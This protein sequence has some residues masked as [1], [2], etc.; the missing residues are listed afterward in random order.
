MRHAI[1]HLD[2]YGE[3]FK[4]GS[5]LT[6]QPPT[7][8]PMSMPSLPMP[9]PLFDNQSIEKTLCSPCK[10]SSICNIKLKKFKEYLK[11]PIWVKCPSSL[12]DNSFKYR[13]KDVIDYCHITCKAQKIYSLVFPGP[14]MIYSDINMHIRQ[15]ENNVPVLH[16]QN[17]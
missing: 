8:P 3:I 11:Q 1:P 7:L 9:L 6:S 14:I 15:F 17:I 4:C 12:S 2:S 10:F 13:F 5:D 16:S